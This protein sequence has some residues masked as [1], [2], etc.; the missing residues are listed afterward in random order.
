MVSSPAF[1]L[2][3]KGW[4]PVYTGLTMA[5]RRPHRG[6]KVWA[7]YRFNVDWNPRRRDWIPALAGMTVL[8]AGRLFM[9]MTAW[10]TWAYRG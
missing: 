10:M 7:P 2:M 8:G 3:C 5:L 1:E 6:M 9:V 4:I